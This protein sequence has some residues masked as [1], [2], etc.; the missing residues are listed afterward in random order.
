[1]TTLVYPT[2]AQAIAHAK[3]TAVA[4]LTWNPTDHLLSRF[5]FG[6]TPAARAWLAKYGPDA[7][8]KQQVAYAA[9]YP[10]Y[11]GNTAVDTASPLL[12]LSP[13][14]LLQ[15]I[16]AT[17][18]T[19]SLNAMDQLTRATLGLQTWSV[20]QLYE[21]LVDFFANHL[22]VQNHNS[23]LYLTRHTLDRDVIRKYATGSFTN[24]L[25]ASA[26]NPA[27]LQYLNL[28]DSTKGSVNE[29]YGRELLELHTVGLHYT[30]SDVKNVAKL[31]TGRTVDQ[32]NHY[33]YDEYIHGTGAV[34]V[35]GFSSAN[36]SAAGGEAAGD[37]LLRY[38]A[39]H[40]YTAQNL[41]RKLCIRF[42]SDTPSTAL[43]DAVAK[44]YTAGKTQIMPMVSTILRST[45]FWESRGRK[46]R[47]PAENLVATVRVLNVRP[48]NLTTALTTMYWVT[49]AMGN[50]P[51]DCPTPNGYPDVAASWRSSSALVAQWNAH[52]SLVSG[53]WSGF[54]AVD[55][56][57]LFGSA[58]TSS[59]AVT[60]LTR[61]LTGTTWTSSAVSA[62]QGFLG[63]VLS[64]PLL[65]S[66]L[67]WL[68]APLAALVLDGP[69]HALR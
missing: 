46:V 29:N 45:E 2:I 54:A 51:L 6:P 53:W 48:T 27:M 62:L 13:Y 60:N 28:A 19:F 15:S 12:K 36:A 11:A 57:A 8:Y 55:V 44:A 32:Y 21:T 43:V 58:T 50:T 59:A 14:D 63:E 69:H 5:A 17:N 33:V 47:R 56:P 52:L 39:A 25:L 26:K 34:K 16:K 30:E 40:A 22:N 9:K 42:V 7:W 66:V 67:R 49:S 61:T 18:A 38:L 31:L 10:G 64:T 20:A 65:L 24:M 3:R 41:A 35:L 23:D 4:P 68:D 1:V 37:A